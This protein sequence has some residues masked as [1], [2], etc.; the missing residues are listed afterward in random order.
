[1]LIAFFASQLPYFLTITN[2]ITIFNF[3][4]VTFVA[5]AGFTIALI[6]G[7]LD[8]SVGS[9][10]GL[11]GVVAGTLFLDGTP[12]G[13]AF[14]A[15]FLVGPVVGVVN[16]LLVTRLRI[17]PLIATLAM[18]FIV[19]ALAFLIAEN[20][21]RQVRDDGFRFA[22]EYAF[23]LP[24]AVY[25]LVVVFAI[26]YVLM[27]YTK[28]G[29]HIA[30]VGGN[31]G[32]ARQAAMNVER[33]RMIIYTLAG[34]FSGLAGV[35]LASILGASDPNAGTGREFVVATAVFLGGASLSGGK[36]SIA[37]TLL[38]VVFVVTL[39]NGLTQMGVRPEPVLLINGALLI[40][41][42]AFDQRPRGGYR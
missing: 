22:R 31:P 1:M 20:E 39:S 11:A 14:L 5:A 33:Y 10:M 12:L 32:A 28:L 38:G 37:G 8:L 6:G 25:F 26:A 3:S 4:V 34:A 41:A 30:A 23:G 40:G 13:I 42:V 24:V 15:G 9:V 27:R 36:G 17:N 2:A 7:G 19:R 21:L 16:G 29:R 35:L 18:L